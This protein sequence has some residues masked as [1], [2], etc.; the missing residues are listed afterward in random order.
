MKKTRRLLGDCIVDV[1]KL[2]ATKIRDLTQADAIALF[3]ALLGRK[4]DPATTALLSKPEA[5]L[6][7]AWKSDTAYVIATDDPSP[8]KVKVV[9]RT[10]GGWQLAELPERIAP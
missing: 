7:K 1:S 2:K 9:W 8:G 4:I 5:D 3:N 10:L 6:L